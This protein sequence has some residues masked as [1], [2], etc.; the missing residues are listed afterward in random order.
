MGAMHKTNP[1]VPTPPT[2][3]VLKELNKEW[4]QIVKHSP[5]TCVSSGPQIYHR[6]FVQHFKNEITIKTN[7]KD[8]YLFIFVFIK[9][10]IHALKYRQ[11]NFTHEK[12]DNMENLENTVNNRGPDRDVSSAL[13][14]FS[15]LQMNG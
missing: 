2:E 4:D 7:T 13:T 11:I 9:K 14:C 15:V 10:L 5:N 1:S 3:V 8:Y 6:K 12:R